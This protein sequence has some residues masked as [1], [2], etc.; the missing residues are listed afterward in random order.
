MTTPQRVRKT[1]ALKGLNRRLNFLQKM[2]EKTFTKVT[3][4][5]KREVKVADEIRRIQIEIANLEIKLAGK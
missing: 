5:G 2:G 4:R 1:T 3:K